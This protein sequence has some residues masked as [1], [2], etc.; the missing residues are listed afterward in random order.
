[1]QVGYQALNFTFDFANEPC[2]G[3]Y[4]KTNRSVK[5]SL[6]FKY[7]RDLL[8]SALDEDVEIDVLVAGG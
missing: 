5:L 2:A 3:A 1:M 6:F 8:S 4:V 7:G